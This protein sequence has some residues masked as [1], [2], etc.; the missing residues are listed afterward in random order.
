MNG[1]NVWGSL[2]P[3][4]DI[5]SLFKWNEPQTLDPFIKWL[6]FMFEYTNIYFKK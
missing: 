2:V 3:Y 5:L 4:G 6:N 1:S